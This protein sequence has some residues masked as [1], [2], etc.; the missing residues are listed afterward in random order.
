MIFEGREGVERFSIIEGFTGFAT[1]D[2][3]DVRA[4]RTVALKLRFAEPLIAD[5]LLR[6]GSILARIIENVALLASSQC[7][8]DENQRPISELRRAAVNAVIID[9]R[10][11]RIDALLVTRRFGDHEL[12]K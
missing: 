2:I 11:R 7:R 4:E 1:E 9:P 12:L 6:E 8:L 3:N 10:D 5:E